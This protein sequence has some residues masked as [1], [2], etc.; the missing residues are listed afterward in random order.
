MALANY[1]IT[2]LSVEADED[3]NRP[4]EMLTRHGVIGKYAPGFSLDDPLDLEDAENWLDAFAE[5]KLAQKAQR[6]VI[7]V[8]D[9]RGL[10]D[11][12]DARLAAKLAEAAQIEEEISLIAAAYLRTITEEELA[13]GS[14][15][16]LKPG[17]KTLVDAVEFQRRRVG[18]SASKVL[19]ENPNLPEHVRK[20]L[21]A[22]ADADAD[23]TAERLRI[24]AENKAREEAEK[25]KKA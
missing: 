10:S 17:S 11:D 6:V 22:R 23:A 18:K 8:L 2:D 3:G 12:A 5:D 7:E 20:P 4:I 13:A 19:E 21:K 9:V 15:H 16:P 1:R 25:A 24:A 14:I